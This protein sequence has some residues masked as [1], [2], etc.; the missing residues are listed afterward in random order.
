MNFLI[1]I[2][3][4]I[5]SRYIDVLDYWIQRQLQLFLNPSENVRQTKG[6]PDID[7]L[8]LTQFGIWGIHQ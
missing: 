1:I 2:R 7:T 5:S 4:L 3:S 6:L 8:L